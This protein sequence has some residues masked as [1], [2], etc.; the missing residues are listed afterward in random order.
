MLELLDEQPGFPNEDLSE[1]NAKYLGLILSK[2]SILAKSHKLAETAYPIFIGTHR[3]LYIAAEHLYDD[4]DALRAVNFGIVAFEAAM[5]LVD[6]DVPT[7]VPECLESNVNGIVNPA[8]RNGVDDY[9]QQSHA[10]LVEKMPQTAAV[11]AEGAA[12]RHGERFP[13]AILGGA[14]AWRFEQDNVED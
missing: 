3:P 10:E 13:L 11:I 6:S 8:N 2:V 7:P 14:V 9:F 4:P 5:L 12:S 1:D